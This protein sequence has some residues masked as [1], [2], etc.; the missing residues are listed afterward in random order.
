MGGELFHADRR[1]DGNRDM[2]KLKVAFFCNFSSVRNNCSN[3]RY[4]KRKSYGLFSVRYELNIFIYI[5]KTALVVQKAILLLQSAINT[6][7]VETI[8]FS[9][10][11][12]T[13]H[14]VLR[15]AL[16]RP[17]SPSASWRGADQLTYLITYLLIPWSRVLEKL[18]GSQLVN[19]FTAF[20]WTRVFI[21]AFTSACHLSLSWSSSNQSTPPHP[22]FWR[23]ILILSSHLRL[24]LPSGLFPSGFPTKILYTP[25]LSP[26][27]ATCPA[28]LLLDL[29]TWTYWVRSTDH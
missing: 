11:D 10:S 3:A 23:C 25:L 22:T 13:T 6:G 21:T 26:P 20:Y 9:V 28:H 14:S 8:S 19:K 24:G 18:T 1:T 5:V 7:F 2:V 16:H 17:A 27:G 15:S 4:K 29:I 12:R